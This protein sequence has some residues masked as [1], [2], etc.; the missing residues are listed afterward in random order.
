MSN[1]TKTLSVEGMSCNH[2]VMSVKKSVGAL[3]GVNKVDVDLA[4]KKVTVEFDSDQ[5]KLESIKESIEDV[6]FDVV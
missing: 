1:E 2:C 4:G 6:G 3:N 5:V